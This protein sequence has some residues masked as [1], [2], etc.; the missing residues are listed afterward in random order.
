MYL[1]EHA[2]LAH[3]AR[4]QLRVL[5]AEVEDEDARGVDVGLRDRLTH[6]HVAH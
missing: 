2:E 4:D 1:A 5:G 6:R 3:P